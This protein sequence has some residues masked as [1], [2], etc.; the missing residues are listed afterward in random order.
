MNNSESQ[1][2]TVFFYGLYMD[3]KILQSKG[4]EIRNAQKVRVEKYQLRIGAMAT[5]L[6]EPSAITYGI[7]Y[8]VTN[9]ELFSLYEGSGID[10]YVREPLMV[11][12]EAN[13]LVSAITCILSSPPEVTE[14]NVEYYEKLVTVTQEYGIPLA[15]FQEC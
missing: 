7:T 5:L 1:L 6:H 2:Y 12:D 8:D 9:E 14:N 15:P 3:P 11:V 13:E 10:A 4:V